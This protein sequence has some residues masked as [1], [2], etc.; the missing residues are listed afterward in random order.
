MTD[1]RW[2]AILARADRWWP[3]VLRVL[4]LSLPFLAGPAFGDALDGTSR[5]LQLTASIGLWALWAVGM[6]LVAIPH[7]STLTPLRIVVPAAVLGAI[8]TTLADGA[9][10]SAVT[11]L[12]VTAAAA[13]VALSPQIGAHWVNGSS[14]GDERR[15]PLRP[16]GPL[17]LGPIPLAWF[18]V[19]VG[20]VSGPLLLAV[21]QWV[22]GGVVLVVGLGIA[23][24]AA[25]ALH[26]LA[27]RWL[28]FVPAGLVVHDYMSVSDPVL[29]KRSAIA[30]FGPALA[31]TDA[32]DLS[33]GALGLALELRTRTP[34]EL[35]F[36]AQPGDEPQ[37]ATLEA[38]VISVSQPGAALGEARRRRIAVG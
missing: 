12:A 28:V 29:F 6:L 21:E 20:S 14:Y 9:S 8:W 4:W 27:R 31:D 10:G 23:W 15:L 30:S 1:S 11:A 2:A 18:A 3:W 35:S 17:L 5:S 19:V 22:L 37:T 13:V 16:P 24:V 33:I 32:Q 25:R 7:T 38:I 36:R 26:A 34:V